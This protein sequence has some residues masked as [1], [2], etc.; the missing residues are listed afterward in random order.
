LG[1]QKDVIGMPKN[2]ERGLWIVLCCISYS[3]ISCSFIQAQN[4]DFKEVDKLNLLAEKYLTSIP[5]KAFQNTKKAMALAQKSNYTQGLAKSHQNLGLFFYHQS[6]FLQSIE[7]YLKALQLFQSIH[8]LEGLAA[9]YNHLGLAYYYSSQLDLATKNYEKALKIYAQL[10]NQ[11]GQAATFGLMGHIHEKK[12]EYSK[13]LYFQNKALKMYQSLKDTAGFALIY[14]N[15]GSIY[16]DQEDFEKA[17]HYFKL[18]LDLNQQIN[19]LVAVQI[20]LNN[21]AD[22]FRKTG[23]FGKALDISF[24]SYALA[25]KLKNKY[26]IRGAYRDISKTYYLMKDYE[27]AFLYLDST[28]HAYQE[29]YTEESAK[30]IAR[31]HTIYEIQEKDKEIALLESKQKLNA[32]LRFVF[33]GGV[34]MLILVGYLVFNRQQLKIKKNKE[35]IRQNQQIYETQ[36]ELTQIELQNAQLK[37]NQLKAELEA[38]NKEL[39]TRALHIIQKNELL[40]QLKGKIDKIQ[41]GKNA[42]HQAAEIKQL[43]N[44]INYSFS[45]DKDWE[46]FKKVFEQVHQDFFN[47]LQSR[48]PD[49]TS[50]E[51]RLCALLKLNLDSEDIATILGVSQDSLRVM[52]YRLRKKMNLEKGMNL[53]NFVM[54]L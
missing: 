29:I 22:T 10:H 30:Q 20:N 36:H 3:F 13:A 6:S 33:L 51:I 39:T 8:H 32:V 25:K 46:D 53:V 9:T 34:L 26:Q 5:E 38:I 27:K 19:H 49:L 35:I 18:S 21:V 14:E 37:E 24:Q 50:G 54:T 40:T 11:K 16:E 47:S 45:L 23:K 4:A 12:R 28:Y 52:R 44:L 41:T 15:I 17:Y 31:M 43:S 42:T 7:H 48:F 1:K 2:L